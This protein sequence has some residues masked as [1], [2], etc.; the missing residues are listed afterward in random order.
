MAGQR[1]TAE[2]ERKM[3]DTTVGW[4]GVGRMGM[5]LCKRLLKS[6]YDLAVYNRTKEKASPLAELGAA[7]VDTPAKLAD[8]DVVF[9]MVA[10]PAAFVEVTIG[11]EGL[12]SVSG[13]APRILVDSSTVSA[14]VSE[15]V[16]AAAAERGC[17]LVAAPVSGNPK[18]VK[19]GK[20]TVVASGPESAYAEVKPLLQA[21]GSGVAYVGP[22]DAARLVKMCHNLLLGIVSETLAETAILAE[23]AGVSRADYMNFINMSVMGSTFT[24]YKSPSIVNLDFAP[25]FTGQL[26]R[27]DFE[28][29]L[30]AGR[31]YSVPLPTAA[32]VHQL[33]IAMIGRGY[34][35]QDFMRLL[36]MSAESAGIGIEPEGKA[37]ADGLS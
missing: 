10:D 2:G 13:A 9:T 23:K 33:I 31:Q 4:I 20:L 30:E 12:F 21:F 6:G 19:A 8:R 29:G 7:V 18:V 17:E 5:E 11:P 14:E 22:G 34:G 37:V 1:Q 27:K 26:L 24:K 36:T 28:L 35:D 15:R 32:L 3:T 25:S 16:R